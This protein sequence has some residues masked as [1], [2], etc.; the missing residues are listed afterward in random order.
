MLRQPGFPPMSRAEMARLGWDECD[1]IIVTGDAY[2][3]H[4][5]FGSAVIA[6]VLIDAGFRTGV[7]AQPRWDRP[8]DV[9]QLGRPRLFFGITAGNVDSMVNLYSPLMQKRRTDAYSPGGA[10][11]LRPNRATIVYCGRLRESYP[12]VKLV[13]G[14]IEASLRRLAHYDFWDDTVRRSILLDAK[15]DII[16]YGMAERAVVEIARR[17]DRDPADA[18]ADIPGTV[19]ATSDQR[20]AT[21]LQPPAQEIP[22]YEEVKTDKAKFLEAFM[23]WYQESD[24]P[25][26]KAIIQ[27]SADR[28]VIQ[29]P[30]ALPLSQEELDRVYDLPYQRKPHPGYGAAGIPA[31]ETVKFSI[32][33]HRGC[34]GSCTFCS[35]RAHQGRVIQRRSERSILAEAGQITQMSDFKGHIT[36][37]GGPTANMYAATCPQ[38]DQARPCRKREC[39]FPERCP[40]LESDLREQLKVL[41]AVRRL[42]GVKKVSIG[43]GLRYDLLGGNA[44]PKSEI[45]NP[46]QEDLEALA[47]NYVSG[48]LR[49][50][51]EHVS[52]RVLNLMRKSSREQYERFMAQFEAVNRRLGRK[53]YLIPYFISSFPGCTAED[54]VELAEFLASARRVHDVPGLIRQVQDF[55]PLPMTLAGAMYHTETDPFSGRKLHVARDIREKKLQRA[56]LQLAEP[57]NYAYARRVL[58]ETGQTKLLGRVERLRGR[59][60]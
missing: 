30:P 32:T 25:H 8:D 44:N 4:P 31:L 13:L 17:L 36:D 29:Y 1:V 48:Q 54:M 24:Q 57:A 14:G 51:P 40:N 3:D 60:A 10:M 38:L 56:L 46:K 43:T 9:R 35:L 20:P 42:P 55:T 49:I 19:I 16:A 26:G 41:D 11:G 58:K 34:L 50:A 22:S 28:L 12:G 27:R 2:V 15:A 53:Q 59:R 23:A 33:S 39:L 21:S 45:R 52:S 18:L 6:R 5:S 7:I 37:V 47:R